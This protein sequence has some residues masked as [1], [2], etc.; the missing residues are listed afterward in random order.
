MAQLRFR[1]A[2]RLSHAYMISAPN[3]EE[4]LRTARQLADGRPKKETAELPA[5]AHKTVRRRVRP[6]RAS[7]V[8][9][10]GSYLIIIAFSGTFR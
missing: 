2:Q 10:C 8:C 7:F 9:V 3:R 4:G 5:R 1:D 6:C